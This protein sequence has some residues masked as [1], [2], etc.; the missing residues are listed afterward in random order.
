MKIAGGVVN[1]PLV[2]GLIAFFLAQS[3]K[4]FTTW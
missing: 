3:T 4:F 1:Y 2:A